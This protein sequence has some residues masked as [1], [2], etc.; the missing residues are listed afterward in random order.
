MTLDMTLDMMTR[1]PTLSI[2]NL[3]GPYYPRDTRQQ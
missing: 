2:G 3:D 1:H